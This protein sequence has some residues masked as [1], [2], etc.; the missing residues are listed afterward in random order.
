MDYNILKI[1]FLAACFSWVWVMKLTYERGLLDFIP[2]YYPTKLRP[3]LDCPHC[4]SGWISI[5]A[6]AFY[7]QVP[8]D[9]IYLFFAPFIS[10]SIVNIIK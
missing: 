5:F 7:M 3:V 1:C 8:S 9:I 2:Q 10:M 6:S 4:L